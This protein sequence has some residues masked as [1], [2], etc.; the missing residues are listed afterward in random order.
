MVDHYFSPIQHIPLKKSIIFSTARGVEISLVV[1]GGVFSKSKVDPGSILLIN[2]AR[3]DQGWRVLDLGCGYGPVGIAI[4]KAVP[5]VKV[6]LSDINERAVA[7]A[8]ENIK[9]NRLDNA[10]ARVSDGFANIPE[11]FNTILLNPPQTAGRNLCITLIRDSFQH[12]EG[13]GIFQMVARHKKGGGTL[14]KIMKE[15]FGT[16]ET[17]ARK[18]GYHVYVSKK[19]C[20]KP[21]IKPP[22]PLPL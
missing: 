9:K 15:N 14:A 16:V 10:E 8:K 18:A 5:S 21:C 11:L 6:L 4:A 2:K 3:I 1:S 12:L 7:L 22:Q 19:I 13:G 17:M 20:F